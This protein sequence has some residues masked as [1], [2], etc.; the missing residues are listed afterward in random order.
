MGVET[1]SSKAE[2][3]SRKTILPDV[4]T[5]VARKTGDGK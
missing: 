4:S 5:V 2:S 1:Y 3:E